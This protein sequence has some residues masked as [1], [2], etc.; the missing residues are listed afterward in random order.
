MTDTLTREQ[1]A[2]LKETFTVFDKDNDGFITLDELESAFKK[3]G[4][5]VTRKELEETIRNVDAD[6]D[7]KV[8]FNEFITLMAG[9]A[10][11]DKEKS[12]R[13]K[14]LRQTFQVF[15]KDGDGFVTREELR[16]V[17]SQLGETLDDQELDEMMTSA[18]ANKDGK[19]D[20]A[21]FCKH[22]ENN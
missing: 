12:N 17:M 11:D 3:L 22:F 4:E 21:E 15:D 5:T 1:L 19:L 8:D 7:G 10:E 9:T 20:F 13:M 16:E 18:D 2:E 6:N 14:E